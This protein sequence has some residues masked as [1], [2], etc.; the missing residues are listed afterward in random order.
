VSDWK[1]NKRSLAKDAARPRADG[2]FTVN[3]T[4]APGSRHRRSV[5]GHPDPLPSAEKIADAM[6][7]ANGVINLIPCRRRKTANAAN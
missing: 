4:G 1:G 3:W 6:A 5:S 7:G 2:G